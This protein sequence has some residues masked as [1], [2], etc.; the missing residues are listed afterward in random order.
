MFESGFEERV[1]STLYA[2]ELDGARFHTPSVQEVLALGESAPLTAELIAQLFAIDPE[3]LDED[4]AIA[5]TVAMQRLA[6]AASGRVALGVTRVVNCTKDQPTVPRELQAAAQLGPALGLGSGGADRL[7]AQAPQIVNCLPATKA[8]LLAGNLSW[9]KAS[10]LATATVGMTADG[11]RRVEDKVLAKSW[12]RAPSAHDAA[13]RRAVDQVDPD[14]ADRK[15]K[16]RERDIRLA[17][18]HYGAGMGEL[19]ASMPS[20]DLD[21]VWTA[22]D[23]HARR[24]KAA[25]DP[26]TLDALRVAFLVHAARSYLTHG[27]PTYCDRI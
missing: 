12:D 25:G 21:L 14:H 19:F 1:A 16:Q 23:A 6:D 20:E 2:F 5:Y 9:R 8:M 18:H 13:V 26:R 3:H 10:S 22:A 24:L 15:R 4:Q 7:V 17:K 11:A 27:D